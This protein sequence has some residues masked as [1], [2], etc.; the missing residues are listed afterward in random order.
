MN[1]ALF[2]ITVAALSWLMSCGSPPS[3]SSSPLPAPPPPQVR[4]VASTTP[5]APKSPPPAK[6]TAATPCPS[7]LL[8]AECPYV[9]SYKQGSMESLFELLLFDDHRFC[10]GGMVGSADMLLT[11]HW[12]L[13]EKVERGIVLREQK[14]G[15]TFW[16]EARDEGI[17]DQSSKVVFSLSMGINELDSSPVFAMGATD[18]PPS[19]MRPV[20][21][22]SNSSYQYYYDLPPV[23]RKNARFAFV[24]DLVRRTPEAPV[25]L[26]VLVFEVP[27]TAL[28]R[29]GCNPKPELRLFDRHYELADGKLMIGRRV[30][31]A[32]TPLTPSLV[33]SA[34]KACKLDEPPEPPGNRTR[35]GATET[36]TV[37]SP[38]RILDLD[39][40]VIQG[41]PWFRHDK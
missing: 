22:T 3:P 5:E 8:P 14:T 40:S 27:P 12:G 28:L 21:G 34:R 7:Q 25:R 36:W 24:G 31:G 30:F 2:P 33:E 38:I 11:G 19:T 20:F 41:K 23:S 35:R 1:K 39:P 6:E 32:H 18:T 37:L 10:F 4:V 13:D 15:E 17:L 16:V 9:G 29:I 26:R